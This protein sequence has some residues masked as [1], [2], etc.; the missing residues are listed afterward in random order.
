MIERC[1]LS[2]FSIFCFRLSLFLFFDSPSDLLKKTEES[3]WWKE[4]KRNMTVEC[5]LEETREIEKRYPFDRWRG[6]VSA[7][8]RRCAREQCTI[9]KSTWASKIASRLASGAASSRSASSSLRVL[10][11]ENETAKKKE[12]ER[13]KDY[14]DMWYG[15]CSSVGSLSP[16]THPLLC[17]FNPLIFIW[18][19]VLSF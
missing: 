18:I 12:K 14:Y 2:Y 10:D 15:F 5:V 8:V 13:K 3:E 1:N 11:I 19:L 7:L 4:R 16:K 9:R 17:L 6:W